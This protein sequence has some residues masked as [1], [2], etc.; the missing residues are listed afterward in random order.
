MRR[1]W[2]VQ[3]TKEEVLLEE[4]IEA[5]AREFFQK[6]KAA[7]RIT[8]MVSYGD[9]IAL[10]DLLARATK[11]DKGLEASQQEDADYLDG[12]AALQGSLP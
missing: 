7:T 5:V 4:T 3:N 2:R 12:T 8:E 6:T 1:F 10:L 11:G 9:D